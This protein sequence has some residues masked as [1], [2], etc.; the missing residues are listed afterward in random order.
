MQNLK[1][2][3]FLKSYKIRSKDIYIK[4]KGFQQSKKIYC[5]TPSHPLGHQCSSWVHC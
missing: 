4:R 1:R 3:K 2:I 5:L